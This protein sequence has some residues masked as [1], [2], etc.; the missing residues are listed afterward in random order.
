MMKLLI[1]NSDSV[2]IYAQPDLALSSDGTRGDGWFSPHFTTAN[3]RLEEAELP[4]HWTGGV[5]KFAG[6][7]WSVHDRD[8][9][10]SLLA[11]AAA[12]DAAT[13]AAKIDRL[14]AAADAYTS[15]YISGVAIG[16]LTIGVLQLKPKAL[17]VSA[18]SSAVWDD[19]Y[20]R[21]ALVTA[22]SVENLDFSSHGPTPHSVPEL[23]AEL[24]M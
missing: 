20:V 22:S 15:G 10:D 6:G 19:Y 12:Q 2:V 18:W 3:S 1:R 8:A 23:R 7:E 13:I 17:A 14:W 16:L 21:K 11:A 24:G 9:Y 4:A 5:W